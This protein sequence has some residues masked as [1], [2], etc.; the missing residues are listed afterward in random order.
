MIAAR[1]PLLDSSL[2]AITMNNTALRHATLVFCTLSLCAPAGAAPVEQVPDMSLED[3]INTEVVSASRKAENLQQV[4]AAVFVITQED[5]A[6][7]GARSLPDVLSMAPGMEVARIG[8]NRWAVSARGGNS[9]FANKLQVLK[10]GRS[11]YSP[12]FS[13]V[14]WET[15]DMPLEDIERIE[16]IRGPN[17]AMW[18]SNAVNGTINIITRKARDTQGGLLAVSSGTEDIKN[19]TARYGTTLGDAGHVRFYAKTYDRRGSFNTDDT[20]A[21]DKGDS[22]M[23]G[24][25][26]D[27][28]LSSGNRLSL[29]G[30]LYRDRNGDSYRFPDARLAAPYVAQVDSSM[31]LSGGHLQGRYESLRDDGSEIVFQSYVTQRTLEAE[32][33]LR[34]ERKTLDLDFQYRLAPSGRHD[35][36]IGANYRN[37]SD[38]VTSPAGSY[39]TFAAP[40]RDFQ[41][42]S[43]F[44]ND[45]I[46]IV[47][48]RFRVTLGARMEHNN[49]SGAAFQPTAR[50]LWTPDPNQTVW[51]ALS[52]ATRTPSR[53]ESDVTI[54]LAVVPPRPPLSPLP[55]WM[56]YQNSGGSAL[57]SEKLDALELGYR[58]RFGHALSFDV[59]AFA[60]RYRDGRILVTGGTPTP[61]PTFTYMVLPENTVYGA[62][63]R[64]SGLEFALFAQITPA[65]RLQPSY[66]W[67]HE[68]AFGLG[69][70]VSEAAARGSMN[71]MPRHQ[72]SLRSQHNLSSSQ[73]LDFWLKY[74]SRFH[75][76]STA[77]TVDVPNRTNLDIR[78]A[79]KASRALE[80]SLVGQNLLHRRTVEYL[81]DE[82]PSVAV[83]TGRGVYVKADFRF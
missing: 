48:E 14:F 15:E 82:L 4:A 19:V 18:G 75:Q 12:L 38:T 25:R 5:I 20:R 13:G 67:M 78:Y 21:S 44:A 62:Q 3:L 17:A 22:G 63:S 30:E 72:L 54:P 24:F 28:L 43:V 51:G 80:L 35:V 57:M 71:K 53:A 64:V 47:P 2:R 83:Q 37:S 1:A 73:Q 10:D 7:S 49:I 76:D 45:D 41:L 65:W 50:F 26:A 8:N 27:W 77:A 70:P 68:T 6:R 32:H 33:V 52:R 46:T 40:S 69:D 81:S 23:A 9:R 55:I 59:T 56:I 42:Q 16:I 74:K 11:I 58:R 66:T 79:W 29:N 31:K 60:H 61:A 39:V 36:L 34:E